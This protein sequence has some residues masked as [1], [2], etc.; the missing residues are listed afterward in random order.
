[1]PIYRVY[2]HFEFSRSVPL[3]A[4]SCHAYSCLGFQVNELFELMKKWDSFCASLPQ[5]VARM[6]SL[7]ELHEQGAECYPEIIVLLAEH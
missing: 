5:L 4:F 6:Q 2:G 1:M 7:S 3:I